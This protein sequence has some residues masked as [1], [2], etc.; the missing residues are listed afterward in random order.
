M[1]GQLFLSKRGHVDKNLL[2]KPLGVSSKFFYSSGISDYT[3]VA[4]S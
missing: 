2:P 3:G 1:S 4:G